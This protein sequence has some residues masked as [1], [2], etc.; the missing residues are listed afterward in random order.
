MKDLGDLHE[1]RRERIVKL[2]NSHDSRHL[3]RAVVSSMSHPVSAAPSAD[4]CTT[5]DYMHTGRYHDLTSPTLVLVETPNE[6]VCGGTVVS[7][8]M[9]GLSSHAQKAWC[10]STS[11]PTAPSA[12]TVVAVIRSLPDGVTNTYSFAGVEGKYVNIILPGKG[13]ILTLCEVKVF[14]EDQI[15]PQSSD[16]ENVAAGAKAVQ[17]STA[18]YLGSAEKAVDGKSDTGYRR[19]SCT[20]TKQETDPWWRVELPGVCNVT[21]VTITNRGDCCGHRINGAQ[22]RIGHSL[23][24]NGNDNKLVAV[25]G[26]LESGVTKTYRFR[27]TEGRYVN[28]FLPGENKILTLC[29][30]EVFADEEF[31]P[32]SFHLHDHCTM[33]NLG[34]KG[35][36]TQSSLYGSGTLAVLGLAQNAVDGNRNSHLKKGSCMQTAIESAPWWRVNLHQKSVIFSVA[37]TNRA[38]YPPEH[39][40]GAEIRIGDSVKNNGKDNSLCATV[41][42]IPAGQTEYFNCSSLLEGNYVTVFLPRE[43][44]LSLCEVEVFG[45]PV[46]PN[47]DDI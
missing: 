5:Q 27:A 43:G 22:I 37:L 16:H 39:L 23:E 2:S 38:D 25:I 15:N 3:Q 21:S 32:E 31:S 40:D 14:A 20:H 47:D 24:N 19:G 9:N 34:P 7:T 4:G 18:D 41:S 28:V 10:P 33:P 44:T 11:T 30:V 8:K 12:G 26:P 6:S 1:P 42:S 46:D 35:G 29:E 45:L 36:A 13:R 17:S